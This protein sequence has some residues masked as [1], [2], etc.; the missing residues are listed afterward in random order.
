MHSVVRQ[1]RRDRREADRK[2]PS[3]KNAVAPEE[4]KGEMDNFQD[5]QLGS[6]TPLVRPEHNL[7]SPFSDLAALRQDMDRIFML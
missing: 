7:L 2:N 4:D 5:L 1:Q 3:F 6:I